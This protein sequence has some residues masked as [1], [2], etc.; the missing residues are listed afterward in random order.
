M[1][2]E[3]SFNPATGI[4]E[5]LVTAGTP[6]ELSLVAAS[7]ASLSSSNEM[8]TLLCRRGTTMDT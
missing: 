2:S 5:N 6:M 7:Q 3:S 1:L 4:V 8:F